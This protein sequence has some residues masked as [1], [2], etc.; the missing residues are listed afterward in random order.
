MPCALDGAS[1]SFGSSSSS[2][3]YNEMSMVIL[4]NLDIFV[5]C[6][7]NQIR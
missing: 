7:D 5:I 3:R 6:D 2:S 1:Y 4:F